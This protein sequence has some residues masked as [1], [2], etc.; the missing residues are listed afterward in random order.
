MKILFCLG[1]YYKDKIGGAE[2]QSSLLIKHLLSFGHEMVYLCQGDSFKLF[3][4]IDDRGLKIY[5]IKRPFKRINTLHYLSKKKIYELLDK[6]NPDIIYQRGDYHFIDIISTYGKE[7]RIPVVSA[8][9]MERHCRKP[10]LY[11]TPSLPFQ[12]INRKLISRYY[13]YSSKIICQTEHQKKLFKDNYD[14]E[15][16]IIPIGHEIPESIPKK[17]KKPTIIWVANIKPL[18]RPEIFIELAKRMSDTGARF[19]M[20]GRPHDQRYYQNM[21]TEIDLIKNLKY[22]GERD[23]DTT[24]DH[25]ARSWILV[26]T[27]ESEGFSNTFV[28]AWMR[29]TPVISMNADP[30]DMI[31]EHGL[32]MMAPTID[33]LEKKIRHLIEHPEKIKIMGDRAKEISYDLYDIQKISRRLERVFLDIV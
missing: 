4:D 21:K 8:L 23:F 16:I 20:I 24:N 22:L 6:I 12:I 31:S 9:S 32:G 29:G 14:I 25:I 18:K 26:S 28:Q 30:D 7:R 5:R 3:P 27:S 1:E 11:I 2:I 33:L 15:S 17:E 13:S 10:K 19:I